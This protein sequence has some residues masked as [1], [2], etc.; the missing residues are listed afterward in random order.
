M[1]LEG[2]PESLECEVPPLYGE[3]S[4][5]DVVVEIAAALRGEGAGRLLDL[6]SD[7]RAFVLLVDSL[8]LS[9]LARGFLK[10]LVKAAD[11]VKWATSTAP[12]TTATALASLTTGV[13]PVKHGILGYRVYSKHVGAIIRSLGFTPAVSSS[14]EELKNSGVKLALNRSPT[15]FE[16]LSSEGVRCFYVSSHADS[17]YTSEI[18]RGA[19]LV[20]AR[21]ISEALHLSL[22]ALRRGRALVYAYWGT[23]DSVSHEYGPYSSPVRYLLAGF[24]KMLLEF[25]RDFKRVRNST[26]I[27]LADH[28]QVSLRGSTRVDLSSIPGFL[29]TLSLPPFGESRFTYLKAE[30]PEGMLRVYE[31]HLEDHAKLLELEEYAPLLGA[32]SRTEVELLSRLAGTHVLLPRGNNLLIY[33]YREDELKSRLKGHHGGLTGYEMLVPVILVNSSR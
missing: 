8:G 13:P 14:R 28:G 27:V 22:K 20:E 7:E 21:G 12:S 30:D 23:L 1:E 4:I 29:E 18:A 24:E 5:V 17:T 11:E 33:P 19:R 10:E 15:L 26:L 6:I 32:T 9:L 25:M 16:L 3:R 31:E 2:V